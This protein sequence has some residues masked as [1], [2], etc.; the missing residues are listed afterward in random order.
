MN[1][2]A[3]SNIYVNGLGRTDVIFSFITMVLHS[4]DVTSKF[5][6]QS[7]YPTL[8][9]GNEDGLWA[10]RLPWYVKKKMLKRAGLPIFRS[11]CFKI[12]LHPWPAFSLYPNEAFS[13][14]HPSPS[15]AHYPD[16]ICAQKFGIFFFSQIRD[17]GDLSHQ[18][19]QHP[20]PNAIDVL[21]V[22]L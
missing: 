22:G 21:S 10:V 19:A 8:E 6:S 12:F 7:Y 15:S 14:I 4:T 1:C 13:S 18:S 16:K 11:K 20:P 9:M 5:W 3:Y 17:F 2:A